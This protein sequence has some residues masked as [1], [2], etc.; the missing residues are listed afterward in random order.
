MF[1]FFEL[2]EIVKYCNLK[3]IMTES[4]FPREEIF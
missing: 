3:K 4:L 1:L 2:K